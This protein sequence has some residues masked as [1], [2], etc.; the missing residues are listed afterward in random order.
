MYDIFLLH[1]VAGGIGIGRKV[2][3]NLGYIQV[4][5]ENIRQATAH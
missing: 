4:A 2:E 1:C 3:F 5:C